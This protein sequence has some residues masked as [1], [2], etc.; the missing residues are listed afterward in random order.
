MIGVHCDVSAT[1]L[2]DIENSANPNA[3]AT[4]SAFSGG[5]LSQT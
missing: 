4:R 3:S 2:Q 1:W 5:G